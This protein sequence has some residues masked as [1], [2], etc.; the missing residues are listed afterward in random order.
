MELGTSFGLLQTSGIPKISD[1]RS[2]VAFPCPS[3]LL[4]FLRERA[5][6]SVFSSYRRYQH[7]QL[8]QT[9][10]Q[11]FPRLSNGRRYLNCKRNSKLFALK[12]M[13]KNTG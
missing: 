13:Y 9:K 1:H 5:S 3:F 11:Q 6:L 4:F 2:T 7:A 12:R 8:R 10:C